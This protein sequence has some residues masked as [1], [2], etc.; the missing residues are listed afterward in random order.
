MKNIKV[1]L[2]YILTL[3]I[4]FSSC[5]DDLDVLPKDDDIFTVENFYAQPGAYRQAISGV[6]GNMSLTGA[7]GPLSSFLEGVDGG[8]SQY[9]RCLWY[10]QDLTT[11]QLIWSYE[12][13]PRT[14]A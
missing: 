10:L 6:Y 8:T 14:T 7:S 4:M 11:D 5:T 3:G 12:N 9:G 13:D 2:L 1:S